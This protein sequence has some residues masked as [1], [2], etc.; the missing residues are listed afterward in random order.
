MPRGTVKVNSAENVHAAPIPGLDGWSL[1]CHRFIVSL[2]TK[3]KL[4]EFCFPWSRD[5]SSCTKFL[6]FR[7]IANWVKRSET[8]K[9]K[10]F[11]RNGKI[12]N[13]KLRVVKE[14]IVAQRRE[15]FSASQH[16]TDGIL[17]STGQTMLQCPPTALLPQP[18]GTAPLPPSTLHCLMAPLS[19][20]SIAQL[21]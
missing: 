4:S 8:K 12:T 6:C 20:C 14:V 3:R 1:G 5:N 11:T 9:R 13:K 17:E 2:F 18:N 15:K 7:K 16:L 21:T 10:D 19:H